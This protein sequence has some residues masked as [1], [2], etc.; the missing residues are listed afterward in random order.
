MGSSWSPKARV[1]VSPHFPQTLT[2]SH[3]HR[4]FPWWLGTTIRC[5]GLVCKHRQRLYSQK[6]SLKTP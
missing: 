2:K 3:R 6:F 1:P 4:R 5:L